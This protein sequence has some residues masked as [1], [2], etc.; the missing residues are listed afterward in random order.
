MSFM[1]F[2]VYRVCIIEILVS[3]HGGGE[4]HH[5]CSR[6]TFLIMRCSASYT[7]VDVGDSE[8]RPMK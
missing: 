8:R 4:E 2:T 1:L 7:D 6:L 5:R 3:V